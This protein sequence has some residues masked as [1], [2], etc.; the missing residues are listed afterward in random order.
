MSQTYEIKPKKAS[1]ITFFSLR[2]YVRITFYKALFAKQWVVYCK[3]PFFGPQQVIEYLGRYTHR[4]AISNHRVQSIENGT[5]TFTAKDYRNKGKK[6][7]VTL[8]DQEFIRRFS[9][10]IL[11]KGFPKIRHY[12]ILRC[13]IKYLF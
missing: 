9:Q 12:G 3:H 13:S 8:T 5:V 7:M 2:T 11:P 1:F 4:V 6:Y 10:H